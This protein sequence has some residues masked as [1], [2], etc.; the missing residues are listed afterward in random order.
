MIK[1][2]I[3]AR[4]GIIAYTNLL[5]LFSQEKA[6]RNL[7]VI[8]H[9]IAGPTL[10]PGGNSNPGWSSDFQNKIGKGGLNN[11]DFFEHQWSGFDLV[12]F[13][14]K[15]D[16]YTSQIATISLGISLK[17]AKG[18]G[19]MNINVAAHSWGTL[20]AHEALSYS[21][22]KVHDWVSFGSPLREDALKPSQVDGKWLDIY[23]DWDPVTWLRLDSPLAHDWQGNFVPSFDAIAPGNQHSALRVNADWN[24][25][26]TNQ[27]FLLNPSVST[28]IILG[29]IFEHT[30]Y[31][32]PLY[33]VIALIRNW[34]RD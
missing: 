22:V 33:N 17:E 5:Y 2:G 15:P 1:R 21:A 8:V 11:S 12:G 19:Y 6:N 32:N 4:E 18:I 24:E 16:W 13:G 20:L 30:A 31:W 25:D 34:V 10:G 28:A 7:L 27:M 26:V 23:S 14:V 9:G 29:P 3:Y